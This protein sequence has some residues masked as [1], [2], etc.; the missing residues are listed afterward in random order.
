[1][2][3]NLGEVVVQAKHADRVVV[4]VF[5]VGVGE[6]TKSKWLPWSGDTQKATT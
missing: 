5:V 4:S 3:I 6:K 1:M 2:C